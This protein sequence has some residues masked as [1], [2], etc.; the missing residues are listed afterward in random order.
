MKQRARQEEDKELK[1]QSILD[2]A[3]AL[4]NLGK[5]TLPS[6]S[7]IASEAGMAKGTLYLYFGTKEEI[8]LA[9]LAEGFANWLETIRDELMA[10][11]PSIEATL[12][13]YSLFCAKNPKTIFLASLSP[14]ILE[15]N[16]SEE[17]AYLFKKKLADEIREIGELMT[18][19][20]PRLS[21]E[22]AR[23]LFINSYALTIGLWQHTHPAPIIEKVFKRE[24]VSILL[25]NFQ[26]DLY[27]ALEVLWRGSLEN[28]RQ[29]L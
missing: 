29:I 27:S 5:Y 15:L 22:H 4:L 9:L 25:M 23:K 21:L 11:S 7:E 6:A 14:A 20:F 17:M 16:I 8:Y 24:E 1:R 19:A 2:A 12:G 28:R 3:E 10:A 26:E 13:S 18:K